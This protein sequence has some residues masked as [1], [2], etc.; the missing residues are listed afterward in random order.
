M[1]MDYKFN[2]KFIFT[3]EFIKYRIYLFSIKN[4]EFEMNK[5]MSINIVIKGS[6]SIT[7]QKFNKKYYQGDIFVLQPGCAVNMK[8]N[9]ENII[10][11]LDV[12]EKFI[13][14]HLG[15]DALED[16]IYYVEDYDKEKI[17]QLMGD[18]YIK[19]FTDL[20]G[21]LI[22]DEYVLNI[23]KHIKSYP[24][25]NKKQLANKDVTEIVHEIAY[26][27]SKYNL[28]MNIKNVNLYD[29]SQEYNVNYY[30]LSRKFKEITSY[31][32]TDYVLI[33]RLNKAINYLINTDDKVYY[34]AEQSGFANVKS[35][36]IG[37]N[38]FFDCTPTNF[39]RKYK[40]INKT[41]VDSLFY[42]DP[43]VKSFLKKSKDYK[44]L[45]EIN[46]IIDIKTSKQYINPDLYINIIDINN[47]IDII[48]NFDNISDI[49]DDS[50]IK[51]IAVNIKFSNNKL[52]LI[53]RNNKLK[54]IT[55]YECN[56]LVNLFEKNAKNVVLIL[57]YNLPETIDEHDDRFFEEFENTINYKINFISKIIGREKLK[58]YSL[59]LNIMNLKELLNNKNEKLVVYHINR[60]LEVVDTKFEGIIYNWGLNI[61][62]TYNYLELQ[63]IN[64]I[65]LSTRNVDMYIIN[66]DWKH[67]Q[68]ITKEETLDLIKKVNGVIDNLYNLSNTKVA[69][70]FSYDITDI[71]LELDHKLNY[72][73]LYSMYILIKFKLM[74]YTTLDI[75]YYMRENKN[76]KY[77]DNFNFNEL[78]IKTDKYYLAN[79]LNSLESEIILFDE[80]VL[81]T[82]SSTGVQI[83][84]FNEY[85]DY[86]KNKG[87]E[88]IKN[89]NILIEGMSG[90]YK[91]IE[92]TGKVDSKHNN[93]K[94]NLLSIVSN[95]EREIFAGNIMPKINI[96]VVEVEKTLKIQVS[97]RTLEV[98]QIKIQKI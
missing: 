43:E 75:E 67:S 9:S 42:D 50:S 51:D 92:Y 32:Y 26:S 49:L 47:I 13:K 57:H 12:K 10:I 24:N 89:Y 35:L 4:E 46:K 7:G 41:F 79:F 6:I 29:I 54:K 3:R 45:N 39:R 25:N 17:Y 84:I 65:I 76:K 81:V 94:D 86:Y 28:D 88:K 64:N 23:L 53:G 82:K 87:E 85:Y 98:K 91:I 30:Y 36:N 97:R 31:T 19:S 11:S 27:I 62:G 63:T 38:K 58:K 72:A 16:K 21:G 69:L 20:W 70:K 33:E 90:T 14:E 78:A 68:L 55:D 60:F 59:S 80:G 93:L 74:G 22:V 2:D 18:L 5:H 61:S 71:N 8:N 48:N 15:M 77:I 96:N 56:Q 95:E 1:D 66:F 73:K 44:K 40:D 34:I 52:Y 37:F 83:L